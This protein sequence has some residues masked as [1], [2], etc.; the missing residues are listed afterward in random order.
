MQT[1]TLSLLSRKEPKDLTLP[2]LSLPGALHRFHLGSTCQSAQNPNCDSGSSL[3]LAPMD[4]SG[5]TIMACLIP[6]FSSLSSAMNIRARLLPEAGGDLMRRYCSP[7]FS[8]ALSC[9]GRIP[10][11]LAL[12]DAPLREY[13]TETDGTDL[14][15]TL[16]YWLLLYASCLWPVRTKR[17]S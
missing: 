16:I 13:V 6:W 4:F 2:P 17:P 8:Y 11:A 7:R 3:K 1:S 9:I 10:R 12:V 14:I 15:L 5:T